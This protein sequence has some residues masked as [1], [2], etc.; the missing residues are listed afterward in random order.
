[1]AELAAFNPLVTIPNYPET[2]AITR[3]SHSATQ[4][5]R[6]VQSLRGLSALAVIVV[7]GFKLAEHALESGSTVQQA[8]SLIEAVGAASV[9]LLFVIS[10]FIM[11]L[12]VDQKPRSPGGFLFDRMTR[13]GPLFWLISLFYLI[14]FVP[15]MAGEGARIMANSFTI[16]PLFDGAIYHTPL[17]FVGWTLAFE[18]AFYALVLLTLIP[19]LMRGDRV[20]QLIVIT[21]ITALIGAFWQS[22]WATARI[23]FNPM[24]LEFLFGAI[25]YH[26]WR[27]GKWGR[28]APAFVVAGVVMLTGQVLFSVGPVLSLNG[29]G[30]IEAGQGLARSLML[31]VPCALIFAGVVFDPSPVKEARHPLEYMGE[32]SYSLYLIQAVVMEWVI[33]TIPVDRFGSAALIAVLVIGGSVLLGLGVYHLFE[34]PF[35]RFLKARRTKHLVPQL[36]AG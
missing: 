2:M 32:A 30:A 3:V 28:F 24:M 23:L 22:A 15:D 11:A 4:R 7:H 18:V 27:S 13:V 6:S 31:G 29:Y 1:M 16:L 33:R 36:A 14:L 9:D 26:M 8:L 34:K 5:L 21:T 12:N 35:L 17:L 19:G 10:G 25:V 20:I